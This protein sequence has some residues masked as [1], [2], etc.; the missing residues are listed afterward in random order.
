[1]WIVSWDF[2]W[3][4]LKNSANEFI[5]VMLSPNNIKKNIIE[6]QR[7]HAIQNFEVKEWKY[8]KDREKADPIA[9]F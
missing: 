5:Y 6:P 2:S 4:S 3:V 9:L 1:M 7:I 8:L